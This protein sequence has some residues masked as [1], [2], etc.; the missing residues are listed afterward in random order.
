M[1][2]VH[3]G[4][5]CAGLTCSLT[6][7]SAPEHTHQ[8]VLSAEPTAMPA[9]SQVP[10]PEMSPKVS[11]EVPLSLLLLQCQLRGLLQLWVWGLLP[12]PP[13]APQVPLPQTLEL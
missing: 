1:A 11:P 2:K 5:L 8:E 9:P 4:G 13:Q 10:H 3:N 7:P 6:L 12:E